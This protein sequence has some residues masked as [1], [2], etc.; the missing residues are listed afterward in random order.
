[1]V[2]LKLGQLSAFASLLLLAFFG[3]LKGQSNDVV[4]LCRIYGNFIPEP[5]GIPPNKG[6]LRQIERHELSF[7]CIFHDK[8]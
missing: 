5:V 4:L 3:I 6:E 1:M 8:S 2:N 7:D